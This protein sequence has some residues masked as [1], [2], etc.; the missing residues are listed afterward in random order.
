MLLAIAN[1]EA[2]SSSSKALATK[3]LEKMAKV[4][5]TREDIQTKFAADQPHPH[6]QGIIPQHVFQ[7]ILDSDTASENSKEQAKS[8]MANLATIK[9]A[10]Q[11][12]TAATKPKPKP[13]Q[14]EMHLYRM[15][16][17]AQQMNREPGKK[18][19]YEGQV[20]ANTDPQA[21]QVYDHFGNTFKFYA[22][23][24]ARNSIDDDGMNLIGSVHFDDDNGIT[25]GYD[26][27]FFDGTQMCFGDGDSEIFNSF[28][29]NL[30]ITAHELTHGVTAYTANLEYHFQSGALNESMSDVFGS[31]VKQYTLN[32]KAV[33]ADWLIGEGLFRD[34][35]GARALRDMANPGTA[36]INNKYIGTDPQPKDMDGYIKL[37]DTQKGDWGGVHYNSGIPN[38][39]FYLAATSLGGYSWD[40]AGK[41]WYATLTDVA[42]TKIKNNKTA[43][44]VFADLTVKHAQE[45]GGDEATAAVTKAWE[46]VKVL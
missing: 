20:P 41:I 34:A 17:D 8:G 9:A 38:R 25:E 12:P 23:I 1:S 15:I 22:D 40:V 14:D 21:K 35:E 3:T 28:T 46:T 30:D 42:L 10:K 18:L 27:A 4:H 26:N 39:A 33:D 43:F 16:Y 11:L 44:K 29:A 37:P 6:P 31:M 2:A 24:F 32:Q 19:F 36:Y 45:I 5:Q 7:A 13:G